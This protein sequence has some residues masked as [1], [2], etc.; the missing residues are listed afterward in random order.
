MS[1]WHY[2]SGGVRQGPVTSEALQA[3]AA[4]GALGPQD[5][6]WNPTLPNW[7]AASTVQGLNFGAGAPRAPV[8]GQ[9]ANPAGQ[10][11]GPTPAPVSLGYSGSA[12]TEVTRRTVDIL[13]ETAPWARIMSIVF[14]INAGICV[15]AALASLAFGA[16]N[17]R[18]PFGRMSSGMAC[19]AFLLYGFLALMTFVPGLFLSQ[20]ASRIGRLRATGRSH[21]LEFALLSQKAYFLFIGILSLIALVLIFLGFLIGL[22]GFARFL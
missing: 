10:Y 7:V 15:L 21:D 16:S 9:A 2:A 14:F 5:L 8:A 6:V 1:E 18:S 3:M 4:S 19:G 12:A 22:L 17:R 11:G 20:Y 13:S